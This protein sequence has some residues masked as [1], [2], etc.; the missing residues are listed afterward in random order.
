MKLETI[1]NETEPTEVQK[2]FDEGVVIYGAGEFGTV[3]LK[4]LQGSHDK[5]RNPIYPDKSQLTLISERDKSSIQQMLYQKCKNPK[6]HSSKS[7]YKDFW[8]ANN[9]KSNFFGTHK[10]ELDIQPKFKITTAS[11]F[12]TPTNQ[13]RDKIEQ[14][15]IHFLCC[16]SKQAPYYKNL[17]NDSALR[18]LI[19]LDGTK[20]HTDPV[21]FTNRNIEY[22]AMSGPNYAGE[23]NAEAPTGIHI[24]AKTKEVREKLKQLFESVDYFVVETSDDPEYVDA[25]GIFK[26]I[27]TFTY[28][29][30]I[31]YISE[32]QQ[33]TDFF[34][35][36]LKDFK[37]YAESR[38]LKTHNFYKDI[39]NLG[40]AFFGDTWM[41]TVHGSSDL[42]GKRSRNYIVSQDLGKKFNRRQ[43]QIDETEQGGDFD[44]SNID[45]FVAYTA[46]KHGI[47]TVE[48]YNSYLKLKEQ[49]IDL[50]ILDFIED[51]LHGKDLTNHDYLQTPNR[52]GYKLFKSQPWHEDFKKLCFYLKKNILDSD[53]AANSIALVMTRA[54]Q[55][56]L[57]ITEALTNN[58]LKNHSKTKG[59]LRE[60]I[61]KLLIDVSQEKI[62]KKELEN[63][64]IEK[65][66]VF[67]QGEKTPL[68]SYLV[69]NF[70]ES[71]DK[72]QGVLNV[73]MN[74]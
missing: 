49:N 21:N 53:R 64:S 52:R 50:P 56:V 16:D 47:K 36:I 18:P 17:I 45:N 23:I 62:D 9:K 6:G 12:F 43:F 3:N 42:S 74:S 55:E 1:P 20:G 34:F 19:L 46:E 57:S 48:G 39:E 22:A 28:G 71:G 40:L 51:A 15:G 25:A 31:N 60:H 54:A 58:K 30:A 7:L 63:I 5:I 70:E 67:T 69:E 27:I 65:L 73:I 13:T 72:F 44:L 35:K 4:A 33:R 26:N 41:C 24:A 66:K 14:L 38:G 68:L 10:P 37:S 59:I 61:I 8:Y 2:T 11:D 32:P 29:I